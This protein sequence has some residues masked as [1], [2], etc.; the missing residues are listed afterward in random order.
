ML[1][2]VLI[3]TTHILK[4]IRVQETDPTLYL[5]E[6]EYVVHIFSP[7]RSPLLRHVDRSG[8]YMYSIYTIYT[9]YIQYMHHK[10]HQYYKKKQFDTICTFQDE[11][12]LTGEA[13]ARGLGV[14]II[15]RSPQF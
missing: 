13:S 10:H 2:V 12:Y 14:Y 7:R 11:F 5:G 6:Q 4:Y 3:K 9:I 8:Y 15:A 1:L